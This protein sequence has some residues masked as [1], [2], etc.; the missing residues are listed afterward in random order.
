MSK[1][2]TRNP[3]EV[4]FN[5]GGSEIKLTPQI[6]KEYV[7]GNANANITNQEY[8]LF[9]ELCKVRQLN[10]FLK[11][12]Y[13]IKYGTAPAQ[14]VVS[15]DAILKRA[16]LHPEYEGHEKGIIVIDRNGE[17]RERV[18]TFRLKDEELVGGWATTF[19]R[20]RKPLKVTV[21]FDEVA[22]KTGQ[23]NLNSNWA[24]KGATM[25][26]KVALVRSLRESFVEDLSGLVDEDEAW[27]NRSKATGKQRHEEEVY[28]IDE[29]P[30]LVNH[31][32][33]EVVE[34]VI[35]AKDL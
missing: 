30:I 13:L 16:I 7:V 8:K 29:E 24:T 23:G 35:D 11:E 12:V 5:V 3:M 22:Q 4:I 34:E 19:R 15:K 9:V 10:P 6:V 1:E 32:T 31:D 20:G 28:I 17:V 33:G 18:G 2:V 26:E 14:M 25:V 27:D 21:S